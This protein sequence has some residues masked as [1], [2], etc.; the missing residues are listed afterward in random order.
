[1]LLALPEKALTLSLPSFFTISGEEDSVKCANPLNEA[2]TSKTEF[3]QVKI[4][5]EFV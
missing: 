5:K 4:M 2:G 1:M 3:S